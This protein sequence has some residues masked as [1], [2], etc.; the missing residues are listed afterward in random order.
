MYT[1]T[2]RN[3]FIDT[4]RAIGRADIGDGNGG[5]FTIDALHALFDYMEDFEQDLGEPIEFDPIGLCC[6]FSEYESAMKAVQDHGGHDQLSVIANENDDE[7]IERKCLEWLQQETA[8]IVFDGGIIIN[9][10]F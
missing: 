10:E 7:E 6:Q 9:S 8:V 5:D 3:D 4:F 2:S 1:N